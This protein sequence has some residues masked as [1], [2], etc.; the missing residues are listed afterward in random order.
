M[1]LTEISATFWL[2][3]SGNVKYSTNTSGYQSEPRWPVSW[4]PGLLV[5]A[6]PNPLAEDLAVGLKK[7]EKKN[8][9]MVKINNKWMI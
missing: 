3:F 5:T 1:P 8:R 6:D 9:S 2:L 7:K 4:L